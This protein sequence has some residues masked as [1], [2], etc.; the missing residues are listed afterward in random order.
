MSIELELNK[1]TLITEDTF[2]V[3]NTNTEN[4]L[5]LN[6]CKS[7]LDNFSASTSLSIKYVW[8]ISNEY[9]NCKIIYQK[10]PKIYPYH[11]SN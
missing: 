4:N 6:F 11:F 1:K 9:S 8:K 10:I 5:I 3:F 7:L 2:M